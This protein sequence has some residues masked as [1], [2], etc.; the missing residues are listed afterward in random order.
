MRRV[1]PKMPLCMNNVQF[2][3]FTNDR[4]FGLP[5]FLD[6]GSNVPQHAAPENRPSSAVQVMKTAAKLLPRSRSIAAH[7]NEPF[8]SQLP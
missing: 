4:F 1:K 5:P 7:T 8:M 3:R 6:K 2:C